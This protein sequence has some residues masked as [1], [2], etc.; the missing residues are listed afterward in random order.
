MIITEAPNALKQHLAMHLDTLDTYEAVRQL[1][2]PRGFGL[3]L[4]RMRVSPLA[5][6]PPNAMDIGKIGD[7]H[8]PTKGK[9]GDKGGK[10]NQKGVIRAREKKVNPRM[11]KEKDPTKARHP[12]PLNS[13]GAIPKDLPREK[14]EVQKEK[15][16]TSRLGMV[17]VCSV[18]QLLLFPTQRLRQ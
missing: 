16:P 11:A 6:I 9:K 15:Y 18:H 14:R 8:Q 13:V 10:G 4:R 5:K 1:F 2:K 12:I 17:S 3:P 7:R